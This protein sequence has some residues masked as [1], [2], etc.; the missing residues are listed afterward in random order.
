MR[1]RND[2][3]VRWNADEQVRGSNA[4]AQAFYQG[5]GFRVCGRLTRQVI[6]DGIEDD[7]V[8]MEVFV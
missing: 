1:E 3:P 5:L 6:M 2:E 8:L 7:E 4:D